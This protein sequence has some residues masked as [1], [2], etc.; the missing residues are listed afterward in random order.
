M[1]Q[2][3]LA[4]IKNVAQFQGMKKIRRLGHS[5]EFEQIKNY[6]IGDDFRSVN[7]KATS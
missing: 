6:V 5:Y 3:E 1:K 2:H 7:W 4:V